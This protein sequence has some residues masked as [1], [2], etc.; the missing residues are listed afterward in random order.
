MTYHVDHVGPME[1]TQKAYKRCSRWFTKFVW[2]YPTKSTDSK[3]VI[4]R[5][6]AIFENPNR[7]ISDRATAFTAQT[8]E[9]DCK[10]NKI[11]HLLIATGVPR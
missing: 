8:S 10:E 11:Q 5:P 3:S 2:L 7:I 9:D 1:L 4:E 6:S